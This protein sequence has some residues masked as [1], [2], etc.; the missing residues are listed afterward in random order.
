MV[1]IHDLTDASKN[2]TKFQL[3][4]ISCQLKLFDIAVTL[5]MDKVTESH[6]N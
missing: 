6:M 3:N 2:P 4:Q 5:N 1:Y